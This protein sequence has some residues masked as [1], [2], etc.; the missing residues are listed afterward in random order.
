MTGARWWVAAAVAVLFLAVAAVWRLPE[1]AVRYVDVPRVI[2]P[3]PPAPGA[4]PA[5]PS[6][7]PKPEVPAR[8]SAAEPAGL[9]DLPRPDPC[10]RPCV[11]VAVTGLGLAADPTARALALP[12]AVALSFSP[13]AGDL[14]IWTARARAEGH[15][16]LLDLPLQPVRYPEDDAGPLTLLVGE[17]AWERNE[18]LTGLLAGR[19][20]WLA[21][22][23]PAGAFAAE[24][25]RFAPIAAALK[26]RGLG[27]VE[28]GA[29]KLGRVAREG[30]LAFARAGRPGA[31]GA[32][33][34]DQALAAAAGEARR[35]GRAL[36]AL[37]PTPVAL[38]R[39]AAWIAGLEATGMALVPA[40][41]I[42][43]GAGQREASRP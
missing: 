14:A 21:A 5:P 15:E 10:A 20:G 18:T 19:E 9:V 4:P 29:D 12:A 36:T 22:A 28:L 38:E 34:V 24:P 23:S 43:A 33:A 7:A 17:P 11:A 16:L 6:V 26:A 27:F 13:Y 8:L 30:G 41:A 2:L 42:L 31:G 25:E 3:V 1:G 37:P 35:A 32:A 39:L 40:G